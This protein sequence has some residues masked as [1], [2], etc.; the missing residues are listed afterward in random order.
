[1]GVFVVCQTSLQ[2]FDR[3][4]QGKVETRTR[5]HEAKWG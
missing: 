4:V 1:M 3:H 5:T 2:A